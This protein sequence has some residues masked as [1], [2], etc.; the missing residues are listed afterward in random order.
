MPDAAEQDKDRFTLSP[1]VMKPRSS[2][3]LLPIARSLMA[4]AAALLVCLALP[5]AAQQKKQPEKKTPATTTPGAAPGGA[6]TF[7]IGTFGDWKALMTGKD[8]QKVCYALSQPK[9]RLPAKLAR[10]PGYLFISNRTADGAKNEI[11]FKLGF[12]TKTGQDGSLAIGTGNFP[13]VGSG[14]SAFLKNPAQEAQL[15]DLM[16]KSS[17]ITLKMSSLRG[18]ETTDKYS[19][20][21]FGK[22]LEAVAKECP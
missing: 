2:R 9:E 4:G 5:A 8:K 6:Q 17:G 12:A 3:A 20:N 1:I 13:L 10:D 7:L 22:A 14:D 16:K 11:A 15:I 21:G 19:L 18:N